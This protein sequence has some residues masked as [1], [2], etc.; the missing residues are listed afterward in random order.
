M[1]AAASAM[2]GADLVGHLAPPFQ[3]RGRAGLVLCHRPAVADDVE[4]D[5]GGRSSRDR[6][7]CHVCPHSTGPAAAV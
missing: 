4:G 5:D 3:R 2:L 1:I 7:F 6:A